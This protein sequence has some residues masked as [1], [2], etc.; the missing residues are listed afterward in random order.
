M[1]LSIAKDEMQHWE[2]IVREET[3][4][5]CTDISEVEGD[6]DTFSED[7]ETRAGLFDR[8][9]LCSRYAAQLERGET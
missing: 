6:G 5:C 8:L 1:L 7:C 4:L 2:Y 3:R 9:T